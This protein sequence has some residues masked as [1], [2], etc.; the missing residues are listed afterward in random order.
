M[1]EPQLV[2]CGGIPRAAA[3]RG[4]PPPEETHELTIGDGK[5]DVHLRINQVSRAMGRCLTDL[6]ADVLEVAAYFYVADQM[7]TRGGTVALDYGRRW[8]RHLRFVIPVRRPDVW[9][10]P[11][12]S[13]TLRAALLFLTD[14]QELEFTFV[15][16]TNPAPR[17]RYIGDMID[18]PADP[19]EVMLF[20]GGLDSLCGAVDE[21]IVGQRPVILVSHRSVSRIQARQ[22]AL[23]AE[24]RRR[25]PHPHLAPVHVGVTINKGEEL[26]RDFTQRGRSFLFAAVAAVVA[27][28]A[29]RRRIRFYENGVTSINLPLS[30]ELVGARASRTTHPQTLARF[31]EFFSNLF[32]C[33]FEVRN[34]F[35]RATKAG[36]LRL[37]K[38]HGHADL[39]SLTV[40]CAHVW[41]QEEA[42]PHCGVCSQCVDRRL[43]AL[44]GGLG[45]AEDPLGRYA[46]DVL[47]GER[48][49]SDLTLVERYVG[50]ALDMEHV[51]NARA[52]ALLYSEVADATSYL[53]MSA[54]DAGQEIFRLHQKHA[55]EI[56]TALRA[57]VAARVN[58]VLARSYPPNSLLGVMVG[59]AACEA[60]PRPVRAAEAGLVVDLDQFEVRFDGRQCFMGNRTE[61]RV[62]ERLARPP[63]G[64]V[65]VE[66]LVGAAW[67][68]RNPSS[69]AVQQVISNIRRL[70]RDNG[71]K[72]L[73]LDGKQPGHYRLV[74][75]P[76]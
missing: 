59:R 49:G 20:S 73:R 35:Q 16:A 3:P 71:L 10:R 37:L 48:T 4:T 69:N 63:I 33:Q 44:A 67:G 53:G 18:V 21:L 76:K 28:L 32:D 68:G 29:G 40:S 12:V 24:L 19:E 15:R 25:A 50:S 56:R 11:E 52:F 45:A 7:V 27:R 17:E 43:T 58:D 61:F 65:S 26:N 75:D 47:V 1:G 36:L 62:V 31:E 42:R 8:R 2:I 54:D 34:P 74:I 51:C 60:G 23:V 39:C 30:R 72:R 57:V 46:S 22:E 38:G 64:Y 6:D 5:R 14:D 70:F 9:N 13:A 55:D 41:G 66:A